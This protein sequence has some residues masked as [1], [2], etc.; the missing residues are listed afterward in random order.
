[1]SIDAPSNAQALRAT[2]LNLVTL[3]HTVAHAKPAF[4]RASPDV[5]VSGRVY[6]ASDMRT[7]VD[8]ALDF[9]LTTG[10]F[11]EAFEAKLAARVGA[12]HALTVN[13]GS[14]ANLVA[15]PR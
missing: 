15:F 5:P 13:S 3:Y 4:D 12:A 14:S 10:R 11:N 1:M 7:L 9:W 6:D 8:C 2:I